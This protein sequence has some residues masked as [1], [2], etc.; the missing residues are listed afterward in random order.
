MGQNGANEA[1][2]FTCE[3]K[4]NAGERLRAKLRPQPIR[5]MRLS[6]QTCKCSVCLMFCTTHEESMTTTLLTPGKTFLPICF[7]NEKEHGEN[8]DRLYWKH[9]FAV[10]VINTGEKNNFNHTLIYFFSPLGASVHFL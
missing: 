7:T 1:F 10:V 5:N 6:P 4:F 3:A 9:I 2:A 8:E